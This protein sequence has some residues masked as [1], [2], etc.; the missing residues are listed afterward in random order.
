MAAT[1]YSLGQIGRLSVAGW[2]D[3]D[4]LSRRQDTELIAIGISH[5]HPADFAVADVGSSR[6]EGEQ[7]V[8]L[9]LLITV[10]RRREVEVQPVLPWLRHQW[11]TAPGDLRT[12]ARRADRG[13]L[14]LVPDQRPAQRFTP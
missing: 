3:R 2:A 13:L 8:D 11:R 9:R 10:R 4:K 14:V 6:S 7:A 5:H 12:A 1:G